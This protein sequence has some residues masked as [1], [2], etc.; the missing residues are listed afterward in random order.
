MGGLSLYLSAFG[1]A[2]LFWRF[3]ASAV[4]VLAVMLLGCGVCL[5]F[6]EWA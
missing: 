5:G 4:V 1:S 6:S 3:V 2:C